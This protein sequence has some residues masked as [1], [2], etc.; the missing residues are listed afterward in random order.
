MKFLHLSDLHLGKRLSGFSLLEDQAF[1]LEQI[2]QIAGEERPDAAL[3]AGDVYDKSVPSAEAVQLFDSFLWDLSGKCPHVFVTSGNHDSPERLAFAARLLDNRGVHL[4]PVYDGSVRPTVLEDE[5]GA[6]RIDMLP[7]LK[8][9][10]VRRFYPEEEIGS[11]TDA[12]RTAIAHLEPGGEERRVLVTHQFVTGAVRS[13]SEEL[14]V[15]G[16]DS[17]DAALFDGFDYVALGHLH[18]PQ[19]VGREALRYCGAPLKYAFSER[20]E[21]SVTV[22]ELREKGTVLLRTAALR[23]LRDMREIRGSYMELTAR[24]F[25]EGSNTGDYIRA[26]LTDEED[27]PEAAARLRAVYPNLMKLEYDNRRTRENVLIDTGPAADRAS[28]L[29]LFAAF[30]EKQNN[31]PL[32]L[33]QREFLAGLIEEIWGETL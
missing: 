19:S 5:F 6:V 4:S 20:Q 31:Q 32:V 1:I 30:Y 2:L 18:S 12:V 14:S 9:A 27:I 22:A 11:Y 26:V 13:E 15:G 24:S 3:I 25:Y 10:H 21:K 17:V 29:E 7:F 28:P 8:P 16:T 23:P 33:E